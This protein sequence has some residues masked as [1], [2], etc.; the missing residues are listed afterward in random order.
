MLTIAIKGSLREPKIGSKS[1]SLAY[2]PLS[3]TSDVSVSD[4]NKMNSSA[5]ESSHSECFVSYNENQEESPN[6]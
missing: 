1:R 5:Y 6:N 3:A 2:M 4:Y